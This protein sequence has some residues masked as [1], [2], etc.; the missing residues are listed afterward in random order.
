MFCCFYFILKLFYCYSYCLSSFIFHVKPFFFNPLF[1]FSRCLQFCFCFTHSGLITR[2]FCF[3]EFFCHFFYLFIRSEEHTS[4]LQSH[5]NLVCRLL[6]EKKT[7][8]STI[9]KLTRPKTL[10]TSILNFTVNS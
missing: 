6:L 3:L 4:E 10:F 2:D 8:Q 7:K 5:V 1:I 9:L